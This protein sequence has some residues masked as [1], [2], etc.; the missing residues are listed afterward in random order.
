MASHVHWSSRAMGSSKFSIT[1]PVQPLVVFSFTL[2]LACILI[3]RSD[4]SSFHSVWK[5][6]NDVLFLQQ[7]RLF[8]GL[9]SNTPVWRKVEKSSH[10]PSPEDDDDDEVSDGLSDTEPAMDS[11]VRSETN[12]PQQP[13]QA[14]LRPRPR[15]PYANYGVELPKVENEEEIKAL[16]E[17]ASYEKEERMAVF[18]EDPEK[19]TKI[20]LS[21]YMKDQGLIW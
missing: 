2:Q 19:S 18:L 7:Y 20:F 15:T 14:P 21:S 10:S 1:H 13:R 11:L 8:I 3:F 6:T 5:R 16:L 4:S 9:L 12:E 17:D